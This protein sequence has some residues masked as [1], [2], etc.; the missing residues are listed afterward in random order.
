M[1]TTEIGE[2]NFNNLKMSPASWIFCSLTLAVVSSAPTSL[3]GPPDGQFT[4]GAPGPGAGSPAGSFGSFSSFIPGGGAGGSMGGPMGGSTGGSI[5][6][7]GSFMPGS[8]GGKGGNMWDQ[9]M[10]GAGGAGS[11]GGS[12]FGGGPGAPS[13]GP[14]GPPGPPGQ[15]G[16]APASA[17]PAGG[18]NQF[19]S[20][21]PGLFGG[22]SGAGKP[23]ASGVPMT[24][25]GFYPAA[26][27]P[28][29]FLKGFGGF[30]PF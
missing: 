27:Q 13:G 8:G 2:G 11:S 10:M 26:A 19:M 22:S 6:G 12:P 4:P 15:V 18:Y 5:P 9:F 25:G 16:S 21:P 17:G 3:D 14:P 1:L 20:P 7:A 28:P 30:M 29:A 24:G 23:G